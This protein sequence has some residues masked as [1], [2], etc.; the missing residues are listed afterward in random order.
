MKVLGFRCDPTAPRYAVVSDNNGFYTLENAASDNKLSLPSSITDD[1]DADRL[2]WLY[3]EVIAIFDA[4]QGIEKV[5]VKQ[6]EYTRSDTKA[7]RKSAHADAAIILACAHK[8]IPVELK[9]YASLETTSTD[10]KRHAESRIG[11]TAKYWDS[12]MA[13]AVNAAWRGLRTP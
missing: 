7:K 1:A 12:K 2:K 8:F 10:T 9:L 6:N 11:K 4:H 13:D 3:L 5:I